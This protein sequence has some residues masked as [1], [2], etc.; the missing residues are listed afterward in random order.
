MLAPFQ[1][2]EMRMIVHS[3]SNDGSVA[4]DR[5]G[6][7]VIPMALKGEPLMLRYVARENLVSTSIGNAKVKVENEGQRSQSKTSWSSDIFCIAY[8]P[9]T[10]FFER[11][12]STSRREN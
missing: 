1:Q 6:W 4:D 12:G 11:L 5:P 9:P 3:F 7:A 8:P 10:N 2:R